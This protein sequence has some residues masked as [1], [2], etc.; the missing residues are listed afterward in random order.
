MNDTAIAWIIYLVTCTILCLLVLNMFRFGSK[1]YLL[2]ALFIL[3]V[4]NIIA[5]IGVPVDHKLNYAN[6]GVIGPMIGKLWLVIF[7]LQTTKIRTRVNPS[8]RLPTIRILLWTFLLLLDIFGVSNRNPDGSFE[9]ILHLTNSSL[10]SLFNTFEIWALPWFVNLQNAWPDHREF[11]HY[12]VQVFLFN[13][14]L[15]GFFEY[16]VIATCDKLSQKV[17][18]MNKKGKLLK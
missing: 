15:F 17:Y 12:L 5:V 3:I 1:R 13:I 6:D 8:W 11:L 9:E 16:V 10:C 2:T 4:L 14:A 18:S 7:F